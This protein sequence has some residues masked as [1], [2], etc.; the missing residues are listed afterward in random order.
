MAYSHVLVVCDGSAEADDAVR[1]ASLI[2]L[3]DH[4][5]LTVVAVAELERGAWGCGIGTSTWNEVL[6]DAAAAD[7]ERARRVVE[8][9]ARFEVVCGRWPRAVSEAASERGCD[10]IMVRRPRRTLIGGRDPSRAM[11][12]V[13]TTTV[14]QPPRLRLSPPGPT[15]AG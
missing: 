8:S 2:A 10:A 9:P 4:A 3:H 6:R 11:R 13:T 15:E 14:L 12:R 5:Q 1:A 7:L